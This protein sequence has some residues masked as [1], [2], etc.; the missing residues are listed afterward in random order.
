MKNIKLYIAEEIEKQHQ[1]EQ[2][3]RLL[4][5]RYLSTSSTQDPKWNSI[6]IRKCNRWEWQKARN[7]AGEKGV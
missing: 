1:N 6:E 5:E 4:V 7:R 2:E 3:Y